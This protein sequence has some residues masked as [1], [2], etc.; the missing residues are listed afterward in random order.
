MGAIPDKPAQVSLTNRPC[1]PLNTING[2]TLEHLEQTSLLHI[3]N[4]SDITTLK[5]A[6]ALAYNIKS[7]DTDGV[8]PLYSIKENETLYLREGVTFEPVGRRELLSLATLT[9]D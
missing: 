4:R 7:V 3:D 2:L 6:I 9:L 8:K 1:L 5:E